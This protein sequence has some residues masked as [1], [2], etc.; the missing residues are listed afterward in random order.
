MKTREEWL[1][2]RKTYL[3][4]TDVAAICGVNQYMTPL[5]VYLDKTTDN[6]D[7]PSNAAMDR[8]NYF[9]PIIAEL[10][11]RKFGVALSEAGTIF[12]P[13]YS[14][15]AANI[16]RMVN[17]GEH[18]L[19]CKTASFYK[20]MKQH[21]GLEGT[22]QIPMGYLAQAAW[23]ATI[24]GK[25]KVDVAALFSS[26]EVWEQAMNDKVDV[27]GTAALIEQGKMELKIYHYYRNVD[28]GE[29]LRREAEYFWNNHIIPRIPPMPANTEEEVSQYS[30]GNGAE[31]KADSIVLGKW[32]S[33][34]DLK[35]REESIQE[36]IK[37]LSMDIKQY[38]KE[39]EILT[40]VEGNCLATWKNTATRMSF[41]AKRFSE[42]YPDLHVQ[43]IKPVK[44]SRMF[45]IK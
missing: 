1:K 40:D 10:Y 18:I 14:Y 23:Y 28:A 19:E 33:L 44:E 22:D 39:S 38:M 43:Y 3:G 21:W 24:A 17:D 11:A 41:D 26:H 30:K 8:G 4:G 37:A 12:H 42:E 6:I 16:D 13:E 45:L 31:V 20:G 32:N 2:E 34:K 27:D 35:I 25:P 15:M 5:D 29:K 9:E 36:E 7:R